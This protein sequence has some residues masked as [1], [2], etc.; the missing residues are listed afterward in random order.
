MATLTLT[1]LYVHDATDL[2]DYVELGQSSEVVGSSQPVEQRRMAGG[3]LR[4]VSR[5][6]VSRTVQL[7]CRGV[8]RTAYNDLVARIGS[9]VLVRDQRGLQLWGVIADVS[10]SEFY[11][12]DLLEQVSFSVTE[13]TWSE[14]V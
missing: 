14:V 1:S 6:G 2:T 11:A 8:T 10:A 3:R 7:T 9:T 4:A 13:V 5:P 12:R